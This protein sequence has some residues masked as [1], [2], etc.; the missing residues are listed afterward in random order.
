MS[1]TPTLIK[2][3]SFAFE[4]FAG[5]C[6]IL[7]GLVHFLYALA[8]VVI[9]RSVPEL[10]AMLSA[11]FLLLAGLLSM[12]AFT[13]AYQRLRDA[14]AGFAL[15]ALLLGSIG[16]LGAA[17]H[18]G[19]DLANLLNPA[20]GPAVDLPSQI[21]PRGLL[22]FGIVGL[23][24]FGFAWLIGRSGQF[25][26]G[27]GYMGYLLGGLFTVIYLARLII[28]DPA[29]PVLL[30]PVLIAGFVVNPGWYVWLGLSLWRG[31]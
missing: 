25:S 23:A 16:T 9:S 14:E 18:G 28:V 27:L 22:T 8:F 26:K 5:M 1:A 30:L 3:E 12:T 17:I 31:K 29:N 24:L 19:Y 15:W 2:Q 10:G 6:A 21:D 20:A 7:A 11:L 13:G 4:K